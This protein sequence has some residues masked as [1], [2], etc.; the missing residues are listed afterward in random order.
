MKILLVLGLHFVVIILTCN[1]KHEQPSHHKMSPPE[2]CGP[3]GKCKCGPTKKYYKVD[4]KNKTYKAVPR[5][6]PPN[7]TKIVLSKNALEYMPE[8]VFVNTPNVTV[9]N[10]TDNCLTKVPMKL[11][12]GTAFLKYLMIASN[13]L[14]ELPPGLL[15]NAPDLKSIDLSSNNLTSVP[16]DL[17]KDKHKLTI[18]IL[19]KN[20]L[21]QLSPT[22]LSSTPNI[23]TLILGSNRIKE[24]PD[25]FFNHTPRL[26]RLSIPMNNIKNV[27]QSTFAGLKSMKYMSFAWNDLSRLT[28]DA[29]GDLHL[30]GSLDLSHNKLKEIPRG[31]FKAKNR[32]HALTMLY[33]QGNNLTFLRSES[34]EGLNRLKYIFLNNNNISWLDCDV[35]NGTN[36]SY[37]YLFGNNLTHLYNDSFRNRNIKEI[38]LYENKIKSISQSALERMN[39]KLKLF[40]NCKNLNYIPWSENF[41]NMTCVNEGFVPRITFNR[42]D[43]KLKLTLKKEGFVCE[44][45]L[46]STTCSP[47]PPGSYGNG[48]GNCLPCARGGFYQ[49]KIG[50]KH[51]KTCVDGTFVNKTNASNF[52]DCTLC[53]EGTNQTRLAGYRACFCKQNYSRTNRFMGCSI[54][55]DSGVNCS[56]DYKFLRHGFYWN[57]SF[58][59]T[60]MTA[61]AQFVANLQTNSSLYDLDTI[62]YNDFMP[63]AHDCPNDDSCSNNNSHTVGNLSGT[64][65]E[66]YRGWMCYQCENYYYRVLNSCRQCP[67]H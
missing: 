35:F 8:D 57:W 4:C 24:I 67:G 55:E 21:Q 40:L 52:A 27:T 41:I 16:A 66:G 2:A 45:H 53:P 44:S 36:V 10:L 46:N 13:Y 19:M 32:S 47:C 9:I 64:C 14:E 37:I 60:N 43:T 58:P 65:A 17:F 11:F 34:F 31:L 29:F 30:Y 62:E 59:R 61:Y 25:G 12:A 38:H 23:S 18:I 20:N 51:C 63:Y 39:T 33:L 5:H 48:H 1:V 15:A 26:D 54:C 7:A 56:F 6:I 3:H 50:M 42:H 49:D 28:S 22:M